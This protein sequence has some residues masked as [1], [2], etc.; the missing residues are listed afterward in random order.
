[1]AKDRAFDAMNPLVEARI[2]AARLRSPVVQGGLP[3]LLKKGDATSSAYQGLVNPKLREDP[4]LRGSDTLGYV[5]DSPYISDTY[6][7]QGLPDEMF[8]QPKLSKPAELVSHE[9]NHIL[10][11]KQGVDV[12]EE[13][14]KLLGDFRVV[15]RKDGTESTRY[16]GQ[17]RTEFV[18]AASAAFP[19]LQEKYGLQSA[20][21]DPKMLEFQNKHGTLPLLLSEQLASLAAI[22]DTQGVDLTKDPVL[23]KTLF[24]D[25]DVR[26]TYNALTG[27]RMTRLDS[28]DLKPLT[29]AEEDEPSMVD[30]LKSM[31]RFA[32][33]G[34][35]PHA[36][37]TKLI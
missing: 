14:D 2:Q 22:E 36:G 12:N 5:M 6:A 1:M 4:S 35:V 11:R 29:R 3:A 13:F 27:L 23:R 37:N 28:K 15:K 30:K 7:N 26:E 21:F 24:K 34:Y 8:V 25:K 19:Y 9:V 32:N 31:V 17:K 18:K 33:G 20:Y 16:L 10:A